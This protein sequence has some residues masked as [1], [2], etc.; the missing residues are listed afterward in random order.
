MIQGLK[1]LLDRFANKAYMI[2]LLW[3]FWFMLRWTQKFLHPC[4]HNH[5]EVKIR[6]GDKNSST[7]EMLDFARE[8]KRKCQSPQS[9]LDEPTHLALIFTPYVY[10]EN[11]SLSLYVYI[12]N[13]LG[14]RWNSVKTFMTERQTY[15]HGDIRALI[16]A[17]LELVWEK[18]VDSVTST[19]VEVSC[20]YRHFADKE[21]LAAVAQEG[22]QMLHHTLGQC[23][24]KHHS[25]HFI[26]LE[27]LCGLCSCSSL[28][29]CL[30]LM[31]YI[32]PTESWVGAGGYTSIH[33]ACQWCKTGQQEGVIVWTTQ[34][35]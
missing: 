3:I 14:F 26:A 25:I 33:G 6:A 19:A 13:M 11:I 24:T 17:A 1:N 30:V 32:C 9:Q 21:A 8:S 31:G 23:C 15:H 28:A 7:E 35:N 34:N 18:D 4:C 10:A 16:E 22:F 12:A 27:L 2:F 20:S 5:E 29:W